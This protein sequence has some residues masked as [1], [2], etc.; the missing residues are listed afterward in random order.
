MHELYK[1]I[2]AASDFFWGGVGFACLFLICLGIYLRSL[3]PSHTEHFSGKPMA[4]DGIIFYVST[5]NQREFN[6]LVTVNGKHKKYFI[7]NTYSTVDRKG[8]RD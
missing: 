8:L 5:G 4:M 6:L 3:D 7:N 2:R 1:K